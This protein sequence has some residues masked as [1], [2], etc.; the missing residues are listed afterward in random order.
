MKPKIIYAVLGATA[1]GFFIGWLIF[2][3]ILASFYKSQTIF[4]Q[5]LQKDPP[6]LWAIVVMNLSFAS[7]LVY[8][9]HTWAGIRTFMKG[10]TTA[11]IIF[12]LVDLGFDIS[13]YGFMNLMSFQGIIVDILANT[14]LG[15]LVGGVAGLIL[16]I[17][18]EKS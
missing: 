13:M 10:F 3:L 5:G 11:L 8:I 14:F 17:G 4:Y 6:E 1:T 7:L 18:E 16:G 9:F 2:G 15:G 12:F